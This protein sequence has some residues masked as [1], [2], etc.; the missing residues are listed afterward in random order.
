[1]Y[2]NMIQMKDRDS[3]CYAAVN[4]WRTDKGTALSYFEQALKQEYI[5]NSPWS[6]AKIY[7][8]IGMAHSSL[9][10][11]TRAYEFLMKAYNSGLVNPSIIKELNWLDNYFKN[12][13]GVNSNSIEEHT[14][15]SSNHKRIMHNCVVEHDYI[16]RRVNIKF[17]DNKKKLSISI[18][19]NLSLKNATLM[20]FNP[21]NTIDRYMGD[22]PDFIFHIVYDSNKDIKSISVERR[23]TGLIFEYNR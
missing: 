5:I 12:T 11:Y 7:S 15:I 18:E 3:L 20:S 13:Q 23:D 6:D 1:M 4:I 21:T 10:N 14:I 17:S 8:N 16:S 9:K 22:D 19:P 2:N